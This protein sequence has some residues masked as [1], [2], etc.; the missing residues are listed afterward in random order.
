MAF[1]LAAC[2]PDF[3]FRFASKY[4]SLLPPFATPSIVF[5]FVCFAELSTVSSHHHVSLSC[6]Q[7]PLVQLQTESQALI[8][9]DLISV[10][11]D[12]TSASESG[13]D[14]KAFVSDSF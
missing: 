4:Y 1:L 7:F 8:K 11:I 10:Q 14:T 2:T 12:P 5:L 3:A 13:S 6:V 9:Q